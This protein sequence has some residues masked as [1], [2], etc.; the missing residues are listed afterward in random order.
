MTTTP[1]LFSV[2]GP[3]LS[4]PVPSLHP[5][6][7]APS[8]AGPAAPFLVVVTGLGPDAARS[9]APPS[10]V[11][12][13]LHRS[14]ADGSS[15]ATR[16]AHPYASDRWIRPLHRQIHPAWVAPSPSAVPAWRAC[17][18][19][20]LQ[21]LRGSLAAVVGSACPHTG[22]P[23]LGCCTLHCHATLASPVRASASA[24]VGADPASPRHVVEPSMV[25]VGPMTPVSA[26]LLGSPSFL[27]T[28]PSNGLVQQSPFTY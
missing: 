16:F 23:Q 20:P 7:W 9:V 13:G 1:P 6:L 17:E 27:T 22:R 21:E 18:L 25:T 8:V 2:V 5:V 19:L 24:L 11:L 28:L 12:C 26:I 4:L 14:H 3:Q 10:P 15:Q